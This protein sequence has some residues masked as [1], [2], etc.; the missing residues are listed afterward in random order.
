M[1]MDMAD[2]DNDDDDDEKDKKDDEKNQIGKFKGKRSMFNSA[3]ED[4]LYGSESDLED[5]DDDDDEG[6]TG[7]GGEVLKKKNKESS[8][9]KKDIVNSWIKEGGGDDDTPVDFLDKGIISK[10]IGVN[11]SNARKQRKDFSKTFKETR[12]G[13]MIIN[14]SDDSNSS[15][16][17]GTDVMMQEADN[18]YMEAQKSSDGFIRGQRNKIKFKKGNKKIDDVDVDDIEPIDVIAS[19]NQKKRKNQGKYSNKVITIGKEYKAKNAGGDIKKKGKP[20]PFAYVPLSTMY[21]KHNQ[22]GPK[23]SITSK[24]KIQKRKGRK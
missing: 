3:Y 19:R 12:D 1:N 21:R 24:S 6:G 18:Y 20:D 9:K 2:D 13:K 4:A 14:E 16:N 7:K 8:K 17:E 10:V 15:E 5:T 11:P 22:K 23:F